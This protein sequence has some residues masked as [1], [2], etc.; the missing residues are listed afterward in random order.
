MTIS[1]PEHGEFESAIRRAVARFKPRKILETGTYLG[2]GTTRMLYES[3][4]EMG[5]PFELITIE[6]NPEYHRIAKERWKSAPEVTCLL[7][8]SILKNQLPDLAEIQR[9]YV[10]N[11]TPGIFHDHP[12]QIRAA[13][14][15]AEANFPGDDGLIVQTLRRFDWRPDLIL[16]DSAGHLGFTEF[17]TVSSFVRHP[18][19]LVLDDVSHL[20]HHKTMRDIAASSKWEIHETGHERF[21]WAICRRRA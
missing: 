9:F 13:L 12:R 20:K 18:F 4:K 2:N 10:D 8:L 21:G 16:L 5:E 14:Y 3:L 11:E 15:F 6:V 19:T 1:P 7:G 17:V